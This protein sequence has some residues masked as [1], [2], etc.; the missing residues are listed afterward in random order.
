MEKVSLSW[1]NDESGEHKIINL[2]RSCRMDVVDG[3]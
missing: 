1:E 3:W 2:I